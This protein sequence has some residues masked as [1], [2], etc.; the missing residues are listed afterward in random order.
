MCGGVGGRA[1]IQPYRCIALAIDLSVDAAAPIPLVAIEATLATCVRELIAVEHLPDIHVARL[2]D[3]RLCP[4]RADEKLDND[5]SFVF[6]LDG[7]SACV[8]THWVEVDDQT[9][10]AGIRRFVGIS[11]GGGRTSVDFALMAAIAV[12]VARRER[13]VIKDWAFFFT[14]VIETEAE[15]FVR[16]LRVKTPQD[17]ILIAARAFDRNLNRLRSPSNS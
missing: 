10:P 17:D 13:T 16:K 3:G 5:H 7:H 14:D 8:A 9:K 15:L 11:A 2:H 6:G 1:T 4:T 12:V